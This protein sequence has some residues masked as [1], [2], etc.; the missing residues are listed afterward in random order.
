M[1][2]KEL[3]IAN[4]VI[5]VVVVFFSV[6]TVNLSAN[7]SLWSVVKQ[8]LRGS[9]PTHVDTVATCTT[10]KPLT[11][12]DTADPQL[13]KLDQYQK[14]CNSYITNTVMFFTTFAANDGEAQQVSA[15]VAAKLK[16]FKASG[17]TP[18]VIAE[19]YIGSG[20]MNYDK[21]NAGQYDEPMQAFFTDLK[22]AGITDDMMGTWVP[23]PE[24]NTPSWDNKDTDP[25]D[26]AHAV[27]RYLGTLR[28]YFPTTKGS[29][30]LDATTYQPTDVNYDNGD[31]LNLTP[32][33]QDIDKTLV[34][35]IGIEGFPWVSRATTTRRE[36]FDA[37]EFLQPDF[38]IAAAQELHTRDIWFNVG[39]FAAKYTNNAADRV[40]LTV[41]ERQAILDSILST[42]NY[43][44]NYQQNQYRVSVNLFAE[45]KSQTSEA[46]DWSFFQDA[47]N[48]QVLK[49]FL[50]N[51]QGKNIPV[52]LYDAKHPGDK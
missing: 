35:S 47:D 5:A 31:Y 19:P 11:V 36:I 52:W 12:T 30:L 32:Y 41:N 23:F 50:A 16:T 2:R 17:V 39:S 15:A 44:Q 9:S 43:V 37:R 38:A 40:N 28:Q 14:L 42:A 49:N 27:N 46:T 33:L 4:C 25:S 7:E 51:A 20:L 13:G 22:A 34:S 26:F 48:E 8:S 3:I 6:M 1:K 21:Y 10:K 29:V 24:S 18:L 45:D